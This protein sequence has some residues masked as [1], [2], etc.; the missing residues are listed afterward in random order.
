MYAELVTIHLGAGMRELAE[1]VA[2]ELVPIYKTMKGFKGVVF[3]GDVETG[4]YGSLSLWDSKEDAE[5]LHRTMKGRLARLVG[6]VPKE[7]PDTRR[8]FEIY[9]TSGPVTN[10]V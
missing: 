2:D 8:I 5:A 6:R 3:M 10:Q 9:E 1:R 4:E 7:K